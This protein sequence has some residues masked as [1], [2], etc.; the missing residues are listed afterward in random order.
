MIFKYLIPFDHFVIH[1]RM[2]SAEA[3]QALQ[4]VVEPRKLFRFS[5]TGAKPFQGM[6]QASGF[7]ITRII[8]YRNSWLPIVAG[9]VEPAPGGSLIRIHMRLMVIIGLFSA[10]WLGA[11]ALVAV[12]FLIKASWQRIEAAPMILMPIGMLAFGLAL[13]NGGFWFEANKQ[14]RMLIDIFGG[15]TV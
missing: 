6:V 4:A 5:S 3:I 15:G 7:R 11:V 8:G 1:S 9:T 10:F 14:K 12:G 2:S 13:T